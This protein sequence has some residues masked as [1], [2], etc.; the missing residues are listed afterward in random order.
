MNKLR[1]EYKIVKQR[2]PHCP[3]CKERLSGNNSIV[4]PYKCSCGTWIQSLIDFNF[5]IK[6]GK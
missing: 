4:M 2:E 6:K 1:P 3:L 5:S